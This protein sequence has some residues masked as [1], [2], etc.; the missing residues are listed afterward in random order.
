MK[1]TWETAQESGTVGSRTRA[2]TQAILPGSSG[3]SQSSTGLTKDKKGR[4]G[5]TADC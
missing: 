5:S 2:V 3:P 1:E 4:M